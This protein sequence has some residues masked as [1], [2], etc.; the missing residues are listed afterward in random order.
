MKRN[1]AYVVSQPKSK[2]IYDEVELPDYE[3]AHAKKTKKNTQTMSK[4][5]SPKKSTR[6]C[7]ALASV[8]GVFSVILL[9]TML[10]VSSV[11]LSAIIELQSKLTMC[12]FTL[13]A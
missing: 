6:V 8:F 11:Q 2:E 10:T 12:S 13:S 9:L 4:K 3:R 1:T 5:Y 7:I